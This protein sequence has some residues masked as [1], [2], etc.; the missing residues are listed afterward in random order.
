MTMIVFGG[1][2][3]T[4]I[5]W[6]VTR[7]LKATGGK[8]TVHDFPDGEKYV[9]LDTA[10][11]GSECVL[12]NSLTNAA[13]IVETLLMLDALTDHGASQV[14]YIAPYLSYM[15]QDKVFKPGEAFSARTLLR[16]LNDRCDTLATFNCHFLSSPGQASFEGVGFTNLDAVDAIVDAVKPKLAAPVVIAPDAGSM[17]Y[18]KQAA[19]RLDCTFNH[20]Q[21]KRISGSEVTIKDKDLDV[22]GKDV[23]ILDDIISTGGTI[24]ESCRIIRGWRP[25]SITVGCVHGLFL[26]GV[27][28]FQGVVDRLVATNTLPNPVAKV[29]IAPA[30]AAFLRG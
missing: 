21:K 7:Q 30:I 25:E 4:D 23:L 10:V 13:D 12:I 17:N 27:E 2:R 8:T 15:R 14:T 9:K 11:G 24:R 5:A 19:E 6:Q 26:T 16:L 18:A 1:T 28:S 22:A 3:S 29:D 20:L